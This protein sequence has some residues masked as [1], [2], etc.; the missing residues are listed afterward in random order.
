MKKF[1]LTYLIAILTLSSCGIYS[2]SGVNYGKAKTVT[3]HYFQNKAPIVNPNLAP[4]L[5]RKLQ[6][7][8]LTETPLTLVDQ[9]GDLDFQG[10]ITGYS[11]APAQVQAGET[12]VANRLTVTVQVKFT[13]RV[14]PQRSFTKTFSW[15][16]DFDPNTN[17]SDVE[18]QLIDQITD[19]L[20]DKI[21]L[22][23][24]SNW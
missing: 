18:D 7:K 5:T 9:G 11:V 6:D 10:T 15:Y 20:V 24:L 8:F 19:V 14:D 17:L 12:A 16:A 23:A 13:D 22:A 2:F 21:F 4:M 3:I 1:I